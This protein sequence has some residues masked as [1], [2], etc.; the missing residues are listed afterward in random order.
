[1]KFRDEE[2]EEK[3]KKVL[4]EVV[5]LK[6]KNLMSENAVDVLKVINVILKMT[7]KWEMKNK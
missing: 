6:K 7:K 1:M 5:S 3:I 2:E 4:E